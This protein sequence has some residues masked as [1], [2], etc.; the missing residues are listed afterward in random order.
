MNSGN[1][2]KIRTRHGRR[3]NHDEELEDAETDVENE[4]MHNEE[5]ENTEADK[6]SEPTD[7]KERKKN[8]STNCS[9]ER[10]QRHKRA[11]AHLNERKLQQIKEWKVAANKKNKINTG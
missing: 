3:T 10:R 8:E 2:E 6:E 1:K 11:R 5:L 7:D 4:P 9:R